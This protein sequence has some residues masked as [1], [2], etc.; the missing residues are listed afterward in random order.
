MRESLASIDVLESA[1][2]VFR[3]FDDGL[4]DAEIQTNKRETFA[5]MDKGAFFIG[6]CIP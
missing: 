1:V 2:E 3:V 5:N 4:I 6:N